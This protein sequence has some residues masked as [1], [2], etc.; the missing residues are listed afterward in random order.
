MSVSSGSCWI[1]MS[2][3]KGDSLLDIL[4]FIIIIIIIM[5]WCRSQAHIPH[6]GEYEMLL[7]VWI[8]LK[9]NDSIHI[10]H[11]GC[12]VSLH[13]FQALFF[14]KNIIG[15]PSFLSSSSAHFLSSLSPLKQ[16]N[17]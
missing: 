11:V 7:R 13:T 9:L 3:S 15:F 10:S 14:L 17:G 8:E 1:L 2:I 4:F 12:R 5:I 6:V 16:W